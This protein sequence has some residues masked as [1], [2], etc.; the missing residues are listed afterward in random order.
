MEIGV[1]V[2]RHKPA[3]LQGVK[4]A[5]SRKWNLVNRPPKIGVGEDHQIKVTP[6]IDSE[7][8]VC[9]PAQSVRMG[10]YGL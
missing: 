4:A 7:R 10:K 9:C 3:L 2:Q 6:G 5:Q 8:R 1:V